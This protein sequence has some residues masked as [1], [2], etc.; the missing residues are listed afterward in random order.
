[1]FVLLLIIKVLLYYFG[2]IWNTCHCWIC[3]MMCP[4]PCVT[5]QDLGQ[6]CSNHSLVEWI[7][8]CI[9]QV[10][11]CLKGTKFVTDV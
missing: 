9:F 2:V 4:I 1:M 7:N 11:M 5:L 3:Q 8:L 10:E 6:T